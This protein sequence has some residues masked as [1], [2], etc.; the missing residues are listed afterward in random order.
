MLR[1][2][3]QQQQGLWGWVRDRR[4]PAG[5]LQ[6]RQLQRSVR[7]HDA[8]RRKSAS[9]AAVDALHVQLSVRQG[10]CAGVPFA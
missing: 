4:L 2:A 5:R 7:A 10:S 1:G 3:G 8:G 6:Q 9:L